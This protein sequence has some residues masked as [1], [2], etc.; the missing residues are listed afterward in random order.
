MGVYTSTYLN[1]KFPGFH[2]QTNLPATLTS[3]F[4]PTEPPAT[5]KG[6]EESETKGKKKI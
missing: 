2:N 5:C 4:D 1:Y 3:I 6:E